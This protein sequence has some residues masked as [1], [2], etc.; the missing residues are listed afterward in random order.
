MT[1]NLFAEIALAPALRLLPP[2]MDTPAARAQLLATALQESRL[3]HRRQVGGPAHGYFQFEKGGGVR[4]VLTHASTYQQAR[5]ICVLLDVD[6]TGDLENEVYEA[7][8]YNDILACV[9]ARLLLWTLPSS[10][11]ARGAAPEGWNQYVAAW[12][13]GKPHRSTWDIYFHSAW[14]IVERSH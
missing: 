12:R 11:P 14:E 13:P 8:V 9:F 2:V 7:V 3:D 4:G 1:P 5:Q 6:Q 10:L